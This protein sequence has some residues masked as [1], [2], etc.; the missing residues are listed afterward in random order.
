VGHLYKFGKSG[1]GQAL[2]YI[3]APVGRGAI[4]MA[5]LQGVRDLST[6]TDKSAVIDRRNL[7]RPLNYGLVLSASAEISG[8]TARRLDRVT[9]RFGLAAEPQATAP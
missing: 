8:E 7:K 2:T 3:K 5:R 6:S 9:K 4:L 1:R